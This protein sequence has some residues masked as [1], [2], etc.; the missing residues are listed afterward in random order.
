MLQTAK[1]M[2]LWE[3]PE[4]THPEHQV[5]EPEGLI[6]SEKSSMSFVKKWRNLKLHHHL[7]IPFL[8]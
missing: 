2:E 4:G 1:A 5:R 7:D 3:A 6:W 8:L